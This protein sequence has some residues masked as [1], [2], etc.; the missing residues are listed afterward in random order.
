M[1]KTLKYLS[2]GLIIYF[3]TIFMPNFFSQKP[4]KFEDF[5]TRE[6]AQAY[7]NTHYPVGSDVNI[8]FTDLKKVG[9]DYI[10]E[11]ERIPPQQMGVG[12]ENTKYDRVYVSKYYNNW[13]S[14]DPMGVYVLYIFILDNGDIVNVSVSQRVKFT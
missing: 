3:M 8:L 10:K 2:I 7:F 1:K 9:V 14:S 12:E 6:K 11:R 5:K 4:F 13:L